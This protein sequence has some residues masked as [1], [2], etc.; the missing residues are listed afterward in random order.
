MRSPRSIRHKARARRLT[1]RPAL[2]LV[3]GFPSHDQGVEQAF[4]FGRVFSQGEQRLALGLR[5][6]SVAKIAGANALYAFECSRA[7]EVA[8]VGLDGC[9]FLRREWQLSKQ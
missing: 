9:E 4:E 8:C 5:V 6:E 2:E 7:T 3:G 1:S